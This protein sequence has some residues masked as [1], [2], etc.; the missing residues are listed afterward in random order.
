[1]DSKLG[2]LR[3]NLYSWM[4]NNTHIYFLSKEEEWPAAL[5]KKL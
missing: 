2:P 5:E 1:M 3:T 4:G